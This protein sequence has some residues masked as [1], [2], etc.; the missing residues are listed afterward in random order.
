[1]K[2]IHD[3]LDHVLARNR[4][5]FWHDGE[6]QWDRKFEEFE[7]AGFQKLRVDGTEL[8]TKVASHLGRV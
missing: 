2:R 4:L 5:V 6:R 3:S 8:R 7:R 1:M